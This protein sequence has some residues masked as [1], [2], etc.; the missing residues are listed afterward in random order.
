MKA[1]GLTLRI[2]CAT[3]VLLALQVFWSR[4]RS[5]AL[6]L[7][8]VPGLL[9]VLAFGR[10]AASSYEHGWNLSG[11]L[12][13]LY[14]GINQL[15]TPDEALLFKVGLKAPRIY[16]MMASGFLTALIFCPLLVLILDCWKKPTQG[17]E[18]GFLLPRREPAIW[19]SLSLQPFRHHLV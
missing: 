12:F 19:L 8:V 11:T 17:D 5:P 10:V 6:G 3:L 2:A 7:F 9:V 18:M 4:P 14:F 16:R 13:V 1:F 15:N